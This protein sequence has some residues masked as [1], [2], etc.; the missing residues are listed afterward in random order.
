MIGKPL[1]RSGISASSIFSRMPARIR[2]AIVKPTP[3]ATPFMN[4]Y[5]MLL[6]ASSVTFIIATPST[7][8]LVVISGRYTPS[9]E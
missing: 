4:A 2:I 3:L 7:A 6:L 8:Q 9:A 5:K 1:K